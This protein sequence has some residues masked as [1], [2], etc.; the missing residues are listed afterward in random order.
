MR[1]AESLPLAARFLVAIVVSGAALSKLSAFDRFRG[2]VAEYRLLPRRAVAPVAG[3][4]ALVESAVA[5]MLI[6]GVAARVAALALDLLLIVFSAA[7][8]INLVRQ[9]RIRCGCT[10]D[11]EQPIS[12][13]HVGRNLALAVLAAGVAARPPVALSLWA[14]WGATGTSR[15]AGDAFAVVMAVVVGLGGASLATRLVRVL[16][17]TGVGA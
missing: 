4:V 3:A 7:I 11:R 17:L 15:G 16:Q 13:G 2:A 10:A 5:A 6:L 12:W 9:R 14:G 1:A 8:A